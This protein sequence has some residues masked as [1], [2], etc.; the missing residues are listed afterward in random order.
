MHLHLAYVQYGGVLSSTIP[1][2]DIRYLH[3]PPLGPLR[4]PLRSLLLSSSPPLP[5]LAPIMAEPATQVVPML[6]PVELQIGCD[7]Q[8]RLSCISDFATDAVR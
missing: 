5:R 4:Y 7:G 6:F 2:M 3:G 8:P 1:G